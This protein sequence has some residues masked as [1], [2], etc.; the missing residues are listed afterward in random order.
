VSIPPDMMSGRHSEA[1]NLLEQVHMALGCVSKLDDFYIVLASLLVDPNA[2]AFSRAFLL[3]Y[4]ERTHS[5]SGRLALGANTR[6]E[7][8][9]FLRDL[10]EETT[11]LK[12]QIEAI[13][14]ESP[15]PF[16]IQALYNLRFHS[17]WI[18]LLQ[19]REEGTGMNAEFQNVTLERD[20]LGLDH[21][22]ERAATTTHAI[23]LEPVGVDIAGL[24][25]F[26]RLPL[27]TGRLATKRGLHGIV[28]T[29]RLFDSH[30]LDDEA[31]YQFQWLLNH[32][33]VSLDNVELVEELTQTTERLQ[34]VDRLKTSFLSIVSHELRTPLTSIVGFTQLLLDEQLG[35][36]TAAQRDLLKRVDQHSANLQSMV[37]DVLEIAEIEAGGMVN[38]EL[39][40][41]DPL[42]ALLNTVG[43]I[44][45]RRGTKK[46]T[47]QPVVRD[48]VPLIRGD[49]RALERIYFHLLD[50]AVKFIPS[51]GTITVEFERH[52]DVLDIMITDT[53]IGIPQENL[54]KIFDYFYQVDFR[55]ER[56]YGGMGIG[57]TVVKLLLD[58]LGGQISVESTPGIGSRFTLSFPVA[59]PGEIAPEI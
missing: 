28:I 31:L 56:A 12:E 35:T 6:D 26:V 39:G 8:E 25:D 9:E 18:H 52:D 11:R 38:V 58:A 23:A 43:K 50:N 5:F 59:W 2:F 21:V 55:L 40:P 13:R 24:E 51:E 48:Q 4:D 37:N 30:T 3:R 17:L 1:L 29:D 42:G 16:A 20:E 19:G 36:L 34:E 14:R 41:V 46:I 10:Q 32:A 53:G 27:I 15:E 45:G 22:L 44:E 47:I 57:L 7:H 49:E 54:K 33:A